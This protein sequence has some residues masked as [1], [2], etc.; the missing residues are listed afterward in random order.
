MHGKRAYVQL[1]I[2][3]SGRGDGDGE[4][5]LSNENCRKVVNGGKMQKERV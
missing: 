4:V 1:A 3:M 5:V 2:K